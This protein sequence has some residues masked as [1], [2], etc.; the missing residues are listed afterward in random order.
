MN[1]YP[2]A[3]CPSAHS[4]DKILLKCKPPAVFGRAQNQLFDPVKRAGYQA[5]AASA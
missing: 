2:Q 5:S 1:A 3:P 4:K